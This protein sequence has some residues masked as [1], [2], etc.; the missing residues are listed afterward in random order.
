MRKS[1][2]FTLVELLVVIAIIG[3]LVALLLPA[4][5]AAREAA[6]RSNCVNNMKQFGIAL[7]NYHDTLKTFPPGGTVKD[8]SEIADDLF[9]SPHAMLLAYFEEQGLKGLYDTKKDWQQQRP[10]VAAK[11]IPVYACPSTTG[12]N[13]YLDQL[14]Q[15]IWIVGSVLNNYNEL[16]VTNYAF[17]KGVTDAQCLGGTGGKAKLPPGPP[18]WV[19]ASERGM[20]DFN[21]AVGIRKISDGTANTIAVGEA[22]HGPKW[23]LAVPPPAGQNAGTWGPMWQGSVPNVTYNNTRTSSPVTDN[24]GQVRIAWQAWIAS[25]SPY[26]SLVAMGVPLYTSNIMACTLEPINKQPVTLSQ[27]DDGNASGTAGCSKSDASAPGTKGKQTTGGTHYSSNYRSDHP[28]GANFLFADGSVHF[29]SETIDMLTYQNLS[30]M[31]GGEIAP[32]PE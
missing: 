5:Q 19:P 12:E 8:S 4:I 3:V 30:T 24:F 17:C 21:W 10:D 27:H 15:Q 18:D 31:A 1:R 13:P 16:G 11:V 29:L 2:A 23:P 25:E 6:R 26:K 22:A 28:G 20:F 14:L 7:H 32:I 9:S